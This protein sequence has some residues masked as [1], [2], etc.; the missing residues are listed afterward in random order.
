VA[1][2]HAEEV[3]PVKDPRTAKPLGG[4][5]DQ[6][7]VQVYNETILRGMN[8]GIADFWGWIYTNDPEFM[9]WSLPEFQADRTLTLSEARAGMYETKEKITKKIED[10][11]Q[12]S[13]NPKA[14]LVNYSYQI[15]TPYARFLKQ[16]SALQA[17]AKNI[18]IA[19]SKKIMAQVIFNYIKDLGEQLKTMRDDETIDPL[20][21]FNY[22]AKLGEQK[23]LV[24]LDQASCEFLIKYINLNQVGDGKVSQ[25]QTQKSTLKGQKDSS[26]VVVKNDK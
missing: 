7:K 10:A 3:Q 15:G 5:T 8:E 25:C 12:Y 1:S 23:S 20:S 26:F 19:D 6:E 11:F 14:V 17:T 21:L 24:H 9:R 16:L 2:V 18:D 4:L 13:E 22:V